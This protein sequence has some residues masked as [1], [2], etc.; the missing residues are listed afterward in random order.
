MVGYHFCGYG[1]DAAGVAG[2]GYAHVNCQD[3]AVGRS[4]GHNRT[5]RSRADL[6]RLQRVR[7]LCQSGFLL[8]KIWDLLDR[9]DLSLR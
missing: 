8:Q 1:L 6:A 9:P 2:S 4:I 3:A 5:G 7:S